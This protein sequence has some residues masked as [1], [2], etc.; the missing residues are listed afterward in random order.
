MIELTKLDE[1]RI[2]VNENYIEIVEE[3][4]DTIITFATGH[5]ILVKESRQEIKNLVKSYHMDINAIDAAHTVKAGHTAVAGGIDAGS[6]SAAGTVSTGSTDRYHKGEK[7][8]T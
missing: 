7:G 2:L 5:K 1:S 8:E 3:T 6:I 4:P